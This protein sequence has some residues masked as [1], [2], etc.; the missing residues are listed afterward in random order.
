MRKKP[1]FDKSVFYL[2]IT[3]TIVA[4]ITIAFKVAPSKKCEKLRWKINP[5]I[6]T[7]KEVVYFID[8]TSGAKSWTWS[9]GDSTE[10]KELSK[11]THVFEKAGTYTVALTINGTC[12]E[13]REIKVMEGVKTNEEALKIVAP[14]RAVA[15][16]T[17][18]FT[19]N[20][21]S[22]KDVE[23]LFEPDTQVV[24]GVNVTYNFAKTGSK[25]IIVYADKRTR[26]AVLEIVVQPQTEEYA[27]TFRATDIIARLYKVMRGEA[28]PSSFRSIICN[29]HTMVKVN[30]EA[31]VQFGNYCD[32]LRTNEVTITSVKWDKDPVSGCI[33][34]LYIQQQ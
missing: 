30:N 22:A 8:E 6:I 33:N 1:V 7:A 32:K 14:A 26:K 16:K 31:P 29:P 10:V 21:K 15:G 5:E 2:F 3:V 25:Q 12:T 34:Y 4:F 20:D 24:R 23:W 9:F 17:I 13:V 11:A 18:R 28:K 27:G 19:V